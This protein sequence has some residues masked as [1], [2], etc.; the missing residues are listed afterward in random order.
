MRITATFLLNLKFVMKR[1]R[2]V[3]SAFTT[4]DRLVMMS[5]LESTDR[6]KCCVYR[7]LHPQL[8]GEGIDKANQ[9]IVLFSLLMTK[10]NF[11]GCARGSILVGTAN[12]EFYSTKLGALVA[13]AIAKTAA[14]AQIASITPKGHA[15]AAMAREGQPSM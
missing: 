13:C 7:K 9:M 12:S 6:K 8:C 2:G 11:G 5:A 3:L 4:N 15:L 1:A 14:A 10:R